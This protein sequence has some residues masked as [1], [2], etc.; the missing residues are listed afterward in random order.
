MSQLIE[1]EQAVNVRELGGYQ[2]K[3]GRLIK[4]K[5]LIR[6]AAISDLTKADQV[7]LAEYGVNQVVDFRS[8]DESRAQP[9]QAIEGAKE[10][11]L[12][13]FQEDET[14]VSLS[15]ESL[16]KR[17]DDGE[18]AEEQM[19]KVYRHFVESPYACKQYR[20]FFD[21]IIENAPSTGATLFHCTAGKDRTGFGAFLLLHVLGV[22]ADTIKQDYLATNRY[23]G[24]MLKA[25]FEPM[26]KDLGDDLLNAISV[27]MRA[28]ESFLDESLT[29]IKARYG[30]VDH[31]IEKGLG[32]RKE[33]QAYLVAHL[34]Q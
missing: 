6:S 32:L 3:Y 34:T 29:T 27:L 30:S 31:Y 14:M 5:K 19:K 16:K 21:Q 7:K 28:E 2:T 10:V 33:E 11:F 20:Q 23:L 12:P 17:L 26:A 1:L 18:D 8:L 15:P 13:I 4:E 9:D 25:K 22:D 24:P